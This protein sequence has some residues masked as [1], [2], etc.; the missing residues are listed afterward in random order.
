VIVNGG[1][2][3]DF[4]RLVSKS[5]TPL[6]SGSLNLKTTLDIP[7]GKE[8]AEVKIKLNGSFVLEDAAFTSAKIQHDVGELSM[9]GQGQPKQAKNAGDGVRSAIESNFTMADGVIQLPNLKYTVP[10]AEIDLIGKYGLNGGT[11][12][13]RGTARTDATVSQMVGGWKGMLLKPAD[14][15]FRKDGAGTLVPIHV[16]GTEHDPA[17][18]IDFGRIG[19]TSPQVPGQIPGQ[20]P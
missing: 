10:G 20:S 8:P 15:I 13:F 19:H 5:G 17:F 16:D 3:E 18:G 12:D 6:M 14:R 9:R 7:P 1:H 11:L 2:M 4:L